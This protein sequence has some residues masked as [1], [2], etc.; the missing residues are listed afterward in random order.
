MTAEDNTH[1][2][3]VD[4]EHFNKI[5]RDVEANTVRLKEHDKE[6][7][8][9]QKTA[10]ASRSAASGH[11]KYSVMAGTPEKMLGKYTHPLVRNY[12]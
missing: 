9:L 12:Y 8:V 11:Y 7:L 10:S 2:L 3:R 6:V 5:L 4:K 1:F